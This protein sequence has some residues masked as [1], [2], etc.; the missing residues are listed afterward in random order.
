MPS[1]V[2]YLL[3]TVLGACLIPATPGLTGVPDASRLRASLERL[4]THGRLYAPASVARFY[5]TRGFALAWESNRVQQLLDSIRATETHGLDPRDYHAADLAGD[6]LAEEHRDILATDA[7]LTLANHLVSGKL[8]P[9]SVEPTWI[10]KARAD[11]PVERLTAALDTDAVTSSLEALA[12]THPDYRLLRAELERYRAITRVGE[13]RSIDS[14][15]LLRRGTRG[16]RVRQLRTRLLASGDLERTEDQASD[17]FDAALERAVERFQRRANLEPDGM[18][19]SMTLRQ[20]N[21]SAQ[22]RLDQLRVNLERWRWLP[23]DLGA[24]HIRVNIADYRLEAHDGGA[25]P[26]VHPVVVGRTYRQT[27]VFSSRMTYVVLN[28]WWGTPPALAR[29]DKLRAF[30]QDPTSVTRLG[31]EVFDDRGRRLDPR[32]IDW[33][34]LDAESFSYRLRQR[35]GPDN[36]LGRMKFMFPNQHDVYVHDTPSYE[37][38]SRTRRDFSSGCIRVKDS[39]DLMVW[40]LAA[41]PD[42]SRERV[43]SVIERGKETQVGL[44]EPIPVHLL[45]FTAV[46]DEATGDVRFIDDVYERDAT[47]LRTLSRFPI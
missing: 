28:P 14:G 38:F 24:K 22:D 3:A 27:P 8:H 39:M 30:Q 23:D 26:R 19:G 25:P 9:I 34:S 7:Y 18:V 17:L 35:P 45:Y 31:F 41:N 36:A 12:P 43:Q 10:P 32:T 20:L 4:K 5:E 6:T 37:L 11:D 29:E 15:E 16:P 40:V 13:W 1:A 33:R 44:R 21:R 2:K 42:W 46:V 47:V